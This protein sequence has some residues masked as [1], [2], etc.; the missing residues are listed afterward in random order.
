M[1]IN[2]EPSFLDRI[3]AVLSPAFKIIKVA[4]DFYVFYKTGHM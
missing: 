2:P 1:L 3:A 4:F